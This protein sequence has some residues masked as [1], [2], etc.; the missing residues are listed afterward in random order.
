MSFSLSDWK[1]LY[2]LD[3]EGY[4]KGDVGKATWA[5][6]M[7]SANEDPRAEWLEAF[8]SGVIE[9]EAEH[10]TAEVWLL[11]ASEGSVFALFGRAEPVAQLRGDYNAEVVRHWIRYGLNAKV[12][13]IAQRCDVSHQYASK[14]RDQWSDEIRS[15]LQ[16]ANCLGLTGE[17]LY[18]A[19]DPRGEPPRQLIQRLRELRDARGS[20][21]GM[22]RSEFERWI[23]AEWFA[24]KQRTGSKYNSE[25]PPT[26]FL[27]TLT[28]EQ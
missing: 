2:T 28:S 15:L 12:I 1:K 10:F 19:C 4:F 24:Y 7:N 18:Y 16:E 20:K 6:V 25:W 23:K 14:I 5:R 22:L 17:D 27:Q 13:D 11:E 9:A 26:W 8:L 3:Y 21:G